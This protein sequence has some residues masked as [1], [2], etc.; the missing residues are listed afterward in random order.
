MKWFSYPAG[1]VVGLV[2]LAVVAWGVYA[3]AKPGGSTY[4]DPAH[5]FSVQLPGPITTKDYPADDGSSDTVVLDDGSGGEVQITITPWDDSGS[6]LTKE[7]AE[8]QYSSISDLD[9]EAIPVAGVFGL[10]FEDSKINESDVWFARGGYLYQ[11]IA[12]GDNTTMQSEAVAGWK[13]Y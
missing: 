3:A 7:A 2:V 8:R 4:V 13:F 6:V 5:R 10:A 11:L 1:I 9:V 12:R